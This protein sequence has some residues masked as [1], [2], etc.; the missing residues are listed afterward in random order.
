MPPV[1]TAMSDWVD[2]E[3]DAC[4]SDSHATRAYPV[5]I[6]IMGPFWEDATPITFSDLLSKDVGGFTS[7]PGYS[8]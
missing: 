1:P 4:G 5:G 6:Q 7:P 3:P 8:E 2:V